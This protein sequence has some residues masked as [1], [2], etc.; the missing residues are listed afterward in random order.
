[1]RFDGANGYYHPGHSEPRRGHVREILCLISETHL[2]IVWGGDNN[3]ESLL[4]RPISDSLGNKME[5][6]TTPDP[7]ASR[8]VSKTTFSL[9]KR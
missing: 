8:A 9:K 3:K 5:A 2:G 7:I 6:K 4:Q 1:M